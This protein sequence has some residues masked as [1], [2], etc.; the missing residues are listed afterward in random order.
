MSLCYVALGTNQ[1]D[2]TENIRVALEEIQEIPETTISKKSSF[3][4]YE[5]EDGADQPPYLNG[6]VELETE[7]PV[8]EVLHKLQV[9]ERKMGRSTKGDGA[10][11]PIDLDILSYGSEVIIQGKTLTLP[12]PRLNTRLFVLEPLCEIAPDWKHP[13]LGLTSQELLNQLGG[14]G[15]STPN[16]NLQDAASVASDASQAKRSS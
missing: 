8:L 10:P 11:R 7:L 13:K 16:E 14:G 3:K 2:R 12:H 15:P 4:E 6:V 5:P 1:G 9:I